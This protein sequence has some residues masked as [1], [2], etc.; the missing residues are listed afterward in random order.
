M[1][2]DSWLSADWPAPGHVQ[3]GTTTRLG[4]KSEGVYSSFNLAQHVGDDKDIVNQNRQRLTSLLNLPS[5]PHWLKQVHGCLVSTDDVIL[6]EADATVTTQKGRV[7]V[8][9]T[10]DCLPVLITDKQ[11]NCVASAHAGWRGL[12]QKIIARTVELMPA[13]PEDL[14]V[15][16]GPA[17]GPQVFEVGDEVRGVFV[18][19]HKKHSSAFIKGHRPGKW[20]MNVYAI[21]RQQLAELG[22]MSVYGGDFCTYQDPQRFYSYRRDNITGRMASLIW[23]T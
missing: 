14:L 21:A 11:G 18:Q 3:A 8:V 1:P 10:A 7:C 17:I 5:D 20:F 4:G 12:E 16:L 13:R 23:M 19:K 6:G 2:A 22:V 9:M 15:W